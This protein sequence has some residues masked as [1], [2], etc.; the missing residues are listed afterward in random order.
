MKGLGSSSSPVRKT[1]KGLTSL[2]MILLLC[3][4]A[5]ADSK[6]PHQLIEIEISLSRI[7]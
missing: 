2:W 4:C 7:S 1:F 3:K 5:T 6:S